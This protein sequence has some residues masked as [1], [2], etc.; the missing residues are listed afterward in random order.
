MSCLKATV[1]ITLQ[2]LF[3]QVIAKMGIL[4]YIM[5]QEDKGTYM[6]MLTSFFDFLKDESRKN[7][8]I[9]ADLIATIDLMKKNGIRLDLNQ[10]IFSIMA[11][12]FYRP[13]LKRTGV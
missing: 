4:R 12:T 9:T 1:S 6:Q 8:E 11:L 13:R 10:V 5:Q 2:Q 3:Q 7:P